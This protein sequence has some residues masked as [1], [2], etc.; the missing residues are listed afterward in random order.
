MKRKWN[1]NDNYFNIID[2]EKKAYLLGFF[3]ADGC[4]STNSK[5]TVGAFRVNIVESDRNII[6]LF[7]DEIVKDR[8]IYNM[9]GKPSLGV[10][11]RQ[12]TC[13]IKWSSIVMKNILETQ[14]NIVPRKTYDENFKMNFN[15]FNPKYVRDFIRGY[16]DGDGCVSICS[17]KTLNIQFYSTSK[18]FLEQISSYIVKEFQYV[19]PKYSCCNRK[20]INLYCLTFAANKYKQLFIEWLF[21]WFYQDSTCYLTRKKEKFLLYLKYKYRDNLE[22]YE[23][24][25]SIVERR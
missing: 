21:K 2:S 22:N 5:N 19:I 23:R 14:Y 17:G 11:R 1:V 13:C 3:I 7:R 4:I 10:K 18:Y 24:F 12:N 15:F 6:E 20:N 16:F 9:I 25:L 8:P